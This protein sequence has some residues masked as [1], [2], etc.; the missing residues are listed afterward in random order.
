MKFTNASIEN[1][2]PGD[3]VQREVTDDDHKGLS[4][5][6]SAKSKTWVF[7]FSADG[8]RRRMILGHYPATDLK[9]ARKAATAAQ[10]LLDQ[11]KSPIGNV[12]TFGAAYERYKKT[13]AEKIKLAANEDA[14]F[15]K[16]ILPT[17][18]NMA[19]NKLNPNAFDDLV[20][21]WAKT[22]GAGQAGPH[23]ALSAFQTWLLSRHLIERPFIPKD[24]APPE[25]Q[26]HETPPLDVVKAVVEWAK[27][28]D[29]TFAEIL[30]VLAWTCLRRSMVTKLT[31][32][33][34]D[35]G[36]GLL[37]FGPDR[38]KGGRPYSQP[39]SKQVSALLAEIKRR[40]EIT[41]RGLS[42]WVWPRLDGKGPTG[43]N[44][45][46]A[47]VGTPLKGYVVHS[48]RGAFASHGREKLNLE[49][50]IVAAVLDHAIFTGATTAYAKGQMYVD[51]RRDALQGWADLLG[52]AP[53]L[54]FAERIKA[55]LA[56]QWAVKAAPDTASA[57]VP[58]V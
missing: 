7:R 41:G 18:E 35:F 23:T 46:N 12:E 38:C 47:V 56:A 57:G 55:D 20:A 54:T 40:Q 10:A 6:V 48:L 58:A 2:T 49:P 28:R 11:G 34:V 53:R 22:L 25:S 13:R 39:M 32:D 33:E 3:A 45:A 42:T 14:M 37:T 9:A 24:Y 50:H 27:D 29:D 4:I 15:R 43:I 26:N 8:K 19:L 1:L 21:V 17:W 51:Q 5:V 30:A 44:P 52:V 16:H 31:W 36:A